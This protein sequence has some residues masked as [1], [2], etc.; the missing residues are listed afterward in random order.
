MTK[1][2]TKSLIRQI[3]GVPGSGK[4]TTVFNSGA[5]S[6]DVHVA[7]FIMTMED[8]GSSLEDMRSYA[9]IGPMLSPGVD[10]DEISR[11]LDSF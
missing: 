11:V 10:W 4:S 2:K 1:T 3:S 9:K 8:R 5:V 6:K 7:Q